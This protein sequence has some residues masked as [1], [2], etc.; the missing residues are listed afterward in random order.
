MLFTSYIKN[1]IYRILYLQYT[2][3]YSIEIKTSRKVNI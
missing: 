3:E 2:F 1:I